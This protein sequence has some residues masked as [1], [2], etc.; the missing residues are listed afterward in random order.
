MAM[1][2]SPGPLYDAGFAAGQS[3]AL[4]NIASALRKFAPD[5]ASQLVRRHSE[6]NIAFENLL[7][8]MRDQEPLSPEEF[9]RREKSD[10]AQPKEG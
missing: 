10:S 6:T 2:G 1:E 8:L 3:S 9:A 5:L 7:R 4:R